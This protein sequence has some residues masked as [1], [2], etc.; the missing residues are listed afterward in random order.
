[1]RL[2]LSLPFRKPYHKDKLQIIHKLTT[3]LIPKLQILLQSKQNKLKI[4]KKGKLQHQ[5]KD[6]W[7]QPKI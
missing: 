7:R 6:I 4:F 5:R 1:M 2:A 3:G